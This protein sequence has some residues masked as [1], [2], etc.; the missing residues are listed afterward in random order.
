MKWCETAPGTAIPG[1]QHTPL[2]TATPCHSFHSHQESQRDQDRNS[3]AECSKV[4]SH[5]T[6]QNMYVMYIYI[7]TL[8]K[9]CRN[10]GNKLGNSWLSNFIS[11]PFTCFDIFFEELRQNDSTTG[12]SGTTASW[13]FQAPLG[14]GWSISSSRLEAMHTEIT[15]L[16]WLQNI[17]NTSEKNWKKILTEKSALSLCNFTISSLQS[18]LQGWPPQNKET[19]TFPAGAEY[20]ASH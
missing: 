3:S 12:T 15:T 4:A 20:G 2:H 5:F 10:H 17:S 18:S 14:Q 8:Y 11:H 6:S 1:F 19:D 13:H 9:P 7:Y 16:P